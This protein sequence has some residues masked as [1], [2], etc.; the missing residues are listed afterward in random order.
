MGRR[1]DADATKLACDLDE[2]DTGQ[3]SMSRVFQSSW[4]KRCSPVLPPLR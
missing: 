3:T 2:G 4:P 1:E